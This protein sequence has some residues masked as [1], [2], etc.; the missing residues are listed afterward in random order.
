M[1]HARHFRLNLGQKVCLAMSE[2]KNVV[3]VKPTN[4][5]LKQEKYLARLT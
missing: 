5:S 4:E 2:K 1:L 3:V